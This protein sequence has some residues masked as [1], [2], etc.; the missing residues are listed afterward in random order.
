MSR[1]I[2]DDLSVLGEG[3][4]SISENLWLHKKNIVDFIQSDYLPANIIGRTSTIQI[5]RIK[6]MKKVS[7]ATLGETLTGVTHQVLNFQS[8]PRIIIIQVLLLVQ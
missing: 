1:T 6:E 8:S 2:T 7:R 4:M 3:M 5:A